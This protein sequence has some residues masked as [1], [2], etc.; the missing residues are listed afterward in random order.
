MCEFFTFS[1]K[2]PKEVF[3][4]HV[5]WG[6][7]K[8]LSPP[9]HG[10]FPKFNASSDNGPHIK[11]NY[12][13][14]QIMVPFKRIYLKKMNICLTVVVISKLI[15][16]TPSKMTK[17]FKMDPTTYPTR[18]VI[19]ALY[20]NCSAGDVDAVALI[21]RF[22]RFSTSELRKGFMNACMYRHID[23]VQYLYPMCKFIHHPDRQYYTISLIFVNSVAY[24]PLHIAAYRQLHIA[25]W[26]ISKHGIGREITTLLLRDCL[27]VVR[28][29][30]VSWSWLISL[31]PAV[32][33]PAV[34]GNF[35]VQK[36]IYYP[37]LYNR[38]QWLSYITPTYKALI[39][40][41]YC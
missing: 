16:Q 2:S 24:R 12:G 3:F 30:S 38:L 31:I 20:R 8:L 40:L 15:K 27:W 22:H 33:I 17:L 35:C 19:N 28:H 25:K 13:G 26:L 11:R 7:R 29:D 37:W 6:L 34:Y 32:Y 5:F 21:V 41:N 23:V 9:I 1:E 18:E 4:V 39:E 14:L 36:Y 10:W